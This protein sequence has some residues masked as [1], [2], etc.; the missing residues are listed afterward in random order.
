MKTEESPHFIEWR[1]KSYNE[2][3]KRKGRPK[4][5]LGQAVLRCGYSSNSDASTALRS[6]F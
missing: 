3:Q 4:K 6:G 2:E 1:V 5:H